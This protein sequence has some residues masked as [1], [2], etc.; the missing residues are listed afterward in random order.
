MCRTKLKQT[1]AD[2]ELLKKCCETLTEENKK[3]KKELQELKASKLTPP[4]YMQLPTAT[5]TVCPSCERVCNGA[6]D[7][8][9]A[10]Q[11]SIGAKPHFFNPF[12][13]PSAAC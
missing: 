2:C 1:E 4:F 8:S 10:G 13:H 3:L 7:G 6:S 12:T 11:F 5:I 9:P